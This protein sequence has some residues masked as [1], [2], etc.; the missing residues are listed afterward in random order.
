MFS[1]CRNLMSNPFVCN[2]HLAWFAEWIRKR[3]LVAG[4]PRCAAPT[5]VRDVAIHELPPHEFKCLSKHTLLSH[6]LCYFF[7]SIVLILALSCKVPHK[8]L[9]KGLTSLVLVFLQFLISI[10]C[11]FLVTSLKA[12]NNLISSDSY[13]KLYQYFKLTVGFVCICR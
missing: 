6:L 12:V 8:K 3:D 10:T 5:R 9:T 2:C 1:A 11:F 4:S 7:L 13:L